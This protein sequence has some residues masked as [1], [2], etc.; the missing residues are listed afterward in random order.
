M[1]MVPIL[2]AGFSLGFER[3]VDAEALFW[4]LLDTRREAAVVRPRTVLPSFDDNGFGEAGV[5]VV[6]LL[7]P[8]ASGGSRSELFNEG[9]KAPF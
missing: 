8:I 5:V 2:L 6:V 3:S 7:D 4:P 1:P 9:D